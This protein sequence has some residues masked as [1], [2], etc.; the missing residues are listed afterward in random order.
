MSGASTPLTPPPLTSASLALAVDELA[1][2]DPDLRSVVERFGRPPLWERPAGFPTLVHIVLEQQVSLA[3]AKAAFDRLRTVADPLTPARFLELDDATLLASG[4]SR[5]KTR[6]VRALATALLDGT[7]D[8]GAI[9]GLDDDAVERELIAI[10][11]IGPVV[12][13]AQNMVFGPVVHEGAEV[14]VS[15]AVDHG[16]GLVDEPEAAPRF[17]PDADTAAIATQTRKDL[18]TEIEEA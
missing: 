4:F 12:V 18:L 2:R 15:W 13:F 1:E 16:F 10:P 7:L 8:L 6:Y 9:A 5:Q 17:A 3:S 14:W 11:G